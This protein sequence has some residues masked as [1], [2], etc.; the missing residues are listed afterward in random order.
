MQKVLL[1]ANGIGVNTNSNYYLNEIEIGLYNILYTAIRIKRRILM[2][3]SK[4][5]FLILVVTCVF[6]LKAVAEDAAEM[7]RKMQ[8]PLASI[9]AI[10]TDNTIGFN[11]GSDEGTSYGFQIQPVYA[12][13]FEEGGFTFIPR[14]VI[15]VT[16]LEPGTKTRFTGEDG[17]PIPTTGTDRVWGLGDSILQFFFAPHSK[18]EWKWGMGP[19]LSVP[20]HTD[21]KLKGPDWGAGLSG[22]ITG[23]ITDNLSFSGI[24]GNHWSF[25]GSFN[26]AT[27]QPILFYNIASM[28]GAYVGY[29]A[30]ISADWN[31]D[32]SNRWTVPLGIT[33]GKTFSVGGGHAFDVSAGPYYNVERP[34]GA[35]DWMLRFGLSWLFP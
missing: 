1:F 2:R 20:T 5:F 13:D 9:K 21:D 24:I 23:S 22:V 16:G 30:S 32:S 31:A 3:Y 28:P 34:E 10:M 4:P 26:V 12:I 33:I 6:P 29:N 15:P 8:N 25:D 14:A 35:A 17:N 7:A 27:I 11:T 18:Q 19:Q